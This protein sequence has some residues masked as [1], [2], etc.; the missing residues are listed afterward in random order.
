MTLLLLLLEVLKEEDDDESVIDE[1]VV[2]PGDGTTE[3]FGCTCIMD[4]DTGIAFVAPFDDGCTEL[5]CCELDTDEFCCK[6]FTEGSC[7][8]TADAANVK[9][10]FC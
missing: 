2:I 3:T 1:A 6:L 5:D 8:P 7:E 10:E 9:E 4:A